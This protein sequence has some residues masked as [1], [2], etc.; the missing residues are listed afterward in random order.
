MLKRNLKFGGLAGTV[1][2]IPLGQPTRAA[3]EIQVYN[4][5]PRDFC[6]LDEAAPSAC[7]TRVAT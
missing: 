2:S 5:P 3:D 4:A 1:L 7:P 6:N